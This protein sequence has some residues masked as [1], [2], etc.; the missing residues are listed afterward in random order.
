MNVRTATKADILGIYN[1]G[2]MNLPIYYSL[3]EL[4]I[5]FMMYEMYVYDVNGSIEG[6]IIIQPKN[7]TGGHIASIAVNEAYRRK[8]VGTILINTS[9]RRPL[10]LNVQ[11]ENTTAIN[12]YRKNGFKEYLLIPNYY[13]GALKGSNDAYEM[14]RI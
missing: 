3:F 2:K 1:C 11:T 12:F 6:Y 9:T 8:G 4:P 5:I 10:T 7:N 14:I 13:H